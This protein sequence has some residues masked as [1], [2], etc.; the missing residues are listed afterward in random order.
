MIASNTH[1]HKQAGVAL[2]LLKFMK[3][4]NDTPMVTQFDHFTNEKVLMEFLTSYKCT[5]GLFKKENP[6]EKH[7]AYYNELKD[8]INPYTRLFTQCQVL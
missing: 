5:T 8:M 7:A 1:T 3:A 2:S 6:P 4:R